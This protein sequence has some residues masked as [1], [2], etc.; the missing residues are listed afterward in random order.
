MTFSILEKLNQ[1]VMAT[2]HYM[3]NQGDVEVEIDLTLEDLEKI[4]KNKRKR[5]RKRQIRRFR[6]DRKPISYYYKQIGYN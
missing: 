6:K 4:L 3:K 2:G 1:E 5:I